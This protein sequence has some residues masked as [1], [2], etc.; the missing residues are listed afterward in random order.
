MGRCNYTMRY[1]LE[2]V[3]ASRGAGGCLPLLLCHRGLGATSFAG[4]TATFHARTAKLD[5]IDSLN[6]FKGT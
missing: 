2:V 4:F 5:I 6:V 1:T 3:K